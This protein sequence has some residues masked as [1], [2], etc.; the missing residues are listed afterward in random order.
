MDADS[1]G[2]LVEQSAD[3]VEPRSEWR[4]RLQAL[5]ESHVRAGPPGPPLLWADAIAHEEGRKS[6]REAR[7]RAA[8][9]LL[10]APHGNRF[11]P[12][13]GHCDAN[14]AKHCAAVNGQ[15]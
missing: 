3:D 10:A 4:Q 15:F 13:K 5:A 2:V 9:Q 8:G 1:C 14:P 7:R 11:E 6:L 12:G